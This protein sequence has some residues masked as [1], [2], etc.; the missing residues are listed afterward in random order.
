MEHFSDRISAGYFIYAEEFELMAADI[1]T[2]FQNRACWRESFNEI[3]AIRV[4][5]NQL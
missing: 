5:R 3:Q 4:R 1:E 2:D